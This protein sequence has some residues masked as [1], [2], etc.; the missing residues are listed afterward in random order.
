MILSFLKSVKHRKNESQDLV[1]G[2]RTTENAD[3]DE[4]RTQQ[5]QPDVRTPNAAAVEIAD[6]HS[7]TINRKIID[8][9]RYQGQQHQSHARKE[10]RHD[11]L[12]VR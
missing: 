10:F 8:E 12:P 1:V 11:D 2:D 4:T 6:G 5:K 3:A 7:E 9:S